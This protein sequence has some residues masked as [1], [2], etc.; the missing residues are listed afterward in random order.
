MKYIL[1]LSFLAFVYAIDLLPIPTEF[2]SW[3][4]TYAKV[5]SLVEYPKRLA[6]FTD[7]LNLIQTL[8]DTAD[9]TEFALNKFADLSAEEFKSLFLGYVPAQDDGTPKETIPPSQQEVPDSFDWI[10]Q[11][12][13]T[14]VKNQGQCG[15]CWAFAATETI[16]SVWLIA[17]GITSDN[18]SPLAPQQIVDC[19]THD[20]GCNGGDPVSAFKYIKS[21]GGQDN[22]VNYPYR[23]VDQNCAFNG[24]DY[25]AKITGYKFATQSNNEEEMKAAIATVSPLSICID[26][27][28]WQFYSS[29][30]L[31]ASKCGT[32]LNHCVQITG[33]DTSN[34]TPYW[35]VRNSWDTDWGEQGY[36][37]LQYGHNTCG[38]T[39][40]ATTVVV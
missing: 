34:D 38:L 39:K 8:K 10:A 18:F 9:G 3:M 20:G 17:N 37:R 31:K 33:Y 21:A 16:E 24:D 19:S 13:V 29:G 11:G 12:K 28:Q 15:S 23:A 32:S 22:D 25:E 5:Y 7:N 2:Q 14:A 30:I 4:D 35:T 1:F 26:A 36:I 40:E 6:I 27:S